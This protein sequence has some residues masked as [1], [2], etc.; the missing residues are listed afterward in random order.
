MLVVDDL[1]TEQKDTL[2]NVISAF[3][4]E[5]GEGIK[6]IGYVVRFEQ[7]INLLDSKAQYALS[8]Q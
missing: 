7:K 6:F 1:S 3:K 5:N 2:I 4:L 8:V